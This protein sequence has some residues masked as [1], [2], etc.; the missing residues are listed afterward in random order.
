M[1]KYSSDVNTLI[2]SLFTV[3]TKMISSH[4]RTCVEISNMSFPQW[5]KLVYMSLLQLANENLLHR[6]PVIKSLHVYNK[7]R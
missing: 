7:Y 5:E 1:G 3:K 6:F 2:F 4:V